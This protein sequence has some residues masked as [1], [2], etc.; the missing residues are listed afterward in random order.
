MTEEPRKRNPR[1]P[2]TPYGQRLE[3]VRIVC[4]KTEAELAKVLRVGGHRYHQFLTGARIPLKKLRDLPSHLRTPDGQQLNVEWLATGKG[5][6]LVAIPEGTLDPRQESRPLQAAA[7]WEELERSPWKDEL[8]PAE[9]AALRRL[10]L[11]DLLFARPSGEAL[12]KMARFFIDQ[13][14]SIRAIN[15]RNPA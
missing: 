10:P 8:E 11:E 1:K 6:M 3:E 4:G 9:L 15:E 13:R 5:P 14:D 2:H 12:K 7:A